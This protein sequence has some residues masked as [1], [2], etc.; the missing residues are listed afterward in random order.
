MSPAAGG[1]SS[2]KMVPCGKCGKSIFIPSTMAPLSTTPCPKCGHPVMLPLKLRQFELRAVIASGGMGTVYRSYDTSLEREVAVKLMRREFTNDKALVES[3]AREAKACAGLN[4]TNIIHIYAFDEWDGEKYI[5]M[6]LAD[7]GSLDD[8]IEKEGAV[9]ELQVLDVGIDVAAALKEASNHNLLH[10]D[11]KPGNILYNSEGKPKLVDF[12]LAR[13]ADAEQAEEEGVLG[14]PYYIAPERVSQTGE[15]YLSDMYSL[16][17]TL[18]LALSGK[19]PFEAPDIQEAAFAHVNTALTPPNHLNPAIT[20]PTNEAIC[21][22]MAKDP[23]QRYQTYDD[24][25]MALESARSHLL[26]Q[27]YRSES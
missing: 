18:Y 17:A 23:A 24:F 22:A 7:C 1:A 3:F 6:E 13:K 16:A 4:H 11:I 25:I 27:K 21:M 9:P 15:S 26:V 12:G 10:L 20:A 19:V 14:T 5:V 2:L 8:R